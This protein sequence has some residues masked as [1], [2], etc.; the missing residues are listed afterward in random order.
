MSWYPSLD[1]YHPRQM[2]INT[3]Q[4]FSLFLVVDR[5]SGRASITTRTS[6]KLEPSRRSRGRYQFT[7]RSR[8]PT[9]RSTLVDADIEDVRVR[10]DGAKLG[11]IDSRGRQRSSVGLIQWLRRRRGRCRGRCDTADIPL[12]EVIRRGTICANQNIIDLDAARCCAGAS[13]AKQRTNIGGRHVL[14]SPSAAG[15]AVRD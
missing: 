1:G 2:R 11:T 8:H 3:L 9:I 15:A 7:P 12:D 10:G 13:K 14:L 6:S 4:D 5:P